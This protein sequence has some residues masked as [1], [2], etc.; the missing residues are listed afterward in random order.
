MSMNLH[1]GRNNIYK[2]DEM[3]I[4]PLQPWTKDVHLFLKYLHD[5]GFT[6][7]P[8]PMGLTQH[9]ERVSFLEGDV[10]TE[11]LPLEMQTDAFMID[12][13]KLIRQFHDFGARYIHKLTGEEPWM[14]TAKTTVETMCHGDLAPYNT[15][16]MDNQIIG[17]IDFDTLHPG[18]RIWDV[19]YALYRF[20]PVMHPENP[21]DLGTHEDK[22]RKVKLFLQAYGSEF[23]N[24][25]ECFDWMVLRLKYLVDFMTE[26][27]SKGN[28]TVIS[29]IEAGHLEGYLKDIHYIQTHW[30]NQ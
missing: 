7:V 10:Y 26:E 3:V 18:S 11:N 2:I 13:A 25:R 19:A 4:R 28:E 21:E 1:G 17:F 27:A 22:Q 6:G 29:H 15:V 5:Q 30:C 16:I 12:L 9:E 20:V 8:K 23:F 24:E 14:L